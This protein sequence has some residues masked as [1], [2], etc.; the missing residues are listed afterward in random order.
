MD[1]FISWGGAAAGVNLVSYAIL[2]AFLVEAETFYLSNRDF[3]G[4]LFRICPFLRVYIGVAGKIGGGGG[5]LTH[6]TQTTAGLSS[7]MMNEIVQ[8]YV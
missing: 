1:W 3:Q 4:V 7:I 5:G 8:I 6:N 2:G